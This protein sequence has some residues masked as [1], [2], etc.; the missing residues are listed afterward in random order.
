MRKK[1]VVVSNYLAPYSTEYH[2]FHVI[3]VEQGCYRH[4]NDQYVVLSIVT[5]P[6]Y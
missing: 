1:T 6:I 4:Y 2:I 3:F 5:T